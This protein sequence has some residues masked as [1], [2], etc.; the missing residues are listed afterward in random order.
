MHY[1]V[2]N[3]TPGQKY[4]VRD[5]SIHDIPAEFTGELVAIRNTLTIFI[6]D[7]ENSAIA[8]P[9][10]ALNEAMSM[11]EITIHDATPFKVY[12]PQREIDTIGKMADAMGI[13]KA[14]VIIR[15]LDMLRFTMR[16][17]EEELDAE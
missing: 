8:I 11:G 12:L 5:H 2:N 4:T 15:A 13:S 9:T 6:S 10:D 17:M 7:D 1:Y 3:L 16:E 14:A